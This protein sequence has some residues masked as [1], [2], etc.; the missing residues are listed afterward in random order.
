LEEFDG[1]HGWFPFDIIN[2]THYEP[3][4]NHPCASLWIVTPC[5]IPTITTMSHDFRRMS[6]GSAAQSPRSVRR[7]PSV[8]YV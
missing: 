8:V 5:K 3:L 4:V 2:I 1:F 6:Q 7:T